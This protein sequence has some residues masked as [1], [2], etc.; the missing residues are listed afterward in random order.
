MFF[1]KIINIENDEVLASNFLPAMESIDVSLWLEKNIVC[2]CELTGKRR[3]QQKIITD[4]YHVFLIAYDSSLSN[5]KFIIYREAC[6][7]FAE[8]IFPKYIKSIESEQK[9]FKRLRHNIISLSTNIT[10]E[11]YQIVPQQS[12]IKGGKNQIQLIA[13]I[14]STDSKGVAEHLLKILKASSLMKSEFDVY[15]MLNTNKPILDIVEHKVHKIINLSL[16]AFWLDFL[17]NNIRIEIQDNHDMVMV[18][19][20]LISVI[21]SHIFDNAIKYCAKGTILNIK[22]KSNFDD[23]DIIF[24][25]TSIKIKSEELENIFVE[26]KSGYYT[27]KAGLSGDGIGMSTIKTLTDLNNGKI[28]I[29][30]NIDEIQ[31]LMINQIPYERNQII[32]T[33]KKSYD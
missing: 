9:R 5:K 32:L 24:E 4:K 22:F 2:T 12:L 33:L 17:K 10:N 6:I 26:G 18:D 15:D 30:S 28:Q 8:K 31:N 7:Y 3:R 14:I 13:D 21:F 11:L 20:T 29:V 16:N 19:Y 25:M 1:F 23:L 27:N